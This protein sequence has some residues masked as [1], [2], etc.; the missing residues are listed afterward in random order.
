MVIRPEGS[1]P[2]PLPEWL[3]LTAVSPN[4]GTGANQAF[5]SRDMLLNLVENGPEYKLND[6]WCIP[7]VL[8]YPKVIFEGL[9]RSEY[10]DGFCF[11]GLPE[12]RRTSQDRETV[13]SPQFMVFLVFAQYQDDKLIVL[14]WEWRRE[15]RNNPGYPLGWKDAFKRQTWPL[16]SPSS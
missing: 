12:K 10:E 8:D 3:Y 6:A 13:D 11:S 2:E 5:I 4:T 1:E 9:N 7:D 14:D 15:D 16:P